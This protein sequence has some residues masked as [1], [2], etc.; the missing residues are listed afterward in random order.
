ME[1][2]CE[3]FLL[4]ASHQYCRDAPECAGLAEKQEPPALNL[5]PRITLTVRQVSG[6]RGRALSERFAPAAV[7]SPWGVQ[8]A[9]CAR[10]LFVFA[11]RLVCI[12]QVI[13]REHYCD[14]PCRFSAVLLLSFV[15]G[16]TAI[17]MQR[18]EGLRHWNLREQGGLSRHPRLAAH[19]ISRV[20]SRPRRKPVLKL[21]SE[22]MVSKRELN[23]ALAPL[24]CR[25]F[26]AI[27]VCEK[28]RFRRP[29]GR[30]SD[31]YL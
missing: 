19:S 29:R 23:R 6:V 3:H 14:P 9:G 17:T 16:A 28:T 12:C 25:R 26:F 22:A 18:L 21:N 15:P 24:L 1:S 31:F 30:Q 5:P 4:L 7:L 11:R 27:K 10:R 8:Q 13:V 2:A 20:W